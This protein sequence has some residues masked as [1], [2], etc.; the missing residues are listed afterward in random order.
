MIGCVLT[1]ARVEDEWCRVCVV[2]REEGE[3]INDLSHFYE[4]TNDQWANHNTGEWCCDTW[5]WEGTKGGKRREGEKKEVSSCQFIFFVFT[6]RHRRIIQIHTSP[7]F[8]HVNNL[9]NRTHHKR[10]NH[11]QHYSWSDFSNILLILFIDK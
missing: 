6:F 1:R 10:K 7:L 5:V 2:S 4:G 9:C 8:D 3:K 11:S